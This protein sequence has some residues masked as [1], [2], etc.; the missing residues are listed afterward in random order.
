MGF[1]PLVG[2]SLVFTVS[3]GPGAL[4]PIDPST[5]DA[6][7]HLT[8]R[9]KAAIIR[10]L[11]RFANDC[12]VQA[13]STSPQLKQS[14]KAGTIGDLIVDSMS[15]CDTAMR[16]MI[17]QHDRLF[18]SGTGEAFFMGPYLDALPA[19]VNKQIKGKESN[20]DR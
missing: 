11:I 5:N 16:T 2:L 20:A 19:T 6:E 8:I 13:V 15:H 1:G 9:Q 3:T 14:I 17:D 4:S 18:G 12:I 10:P 7:T